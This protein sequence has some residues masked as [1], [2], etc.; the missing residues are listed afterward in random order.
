MS[1]INYAHIYDGDLVHGTLSD[2]DGSPKVTWSYNENGQ[3]VTVEREIDE[4]KFAK[5]WN[6]IPDS[7]MFL[8]YRVRDPEAVIDPGRCHVV[9]IVFEID[10]QQKQM[11]YMI[12]ADADEREFESWLE[13][14]DVPVGNR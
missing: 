14:L 3:R 9:M 2:L 8:K 4:M 7:A 10:D 11:A 12:P 13:L 1:V 5:L 6:W